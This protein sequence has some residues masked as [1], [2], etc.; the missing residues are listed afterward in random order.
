MVEKDL[1]S[2][3]YRFESDR[4]DCGGLGVVNFERARI[5]TTSLE[6]SPEVRRVEL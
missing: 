2:F 5:C 4:G 3:Q 1:K 6:M